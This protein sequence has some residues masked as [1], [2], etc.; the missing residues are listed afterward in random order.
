MTM[1]RRESLKTLA[2]GAGALLTF[3]TGGL[4]APQAASAQSGTP[5]GPAGPFVVPPLG[6]AFDALEP[7]IDAQTMQIHHDKHHAT[8]VSKLN[9]AV[10]NHA[11]LQKQSVEQLLTQLNKVPAV[12]RTAVRNHGGGHYNHSLLW[13]SLRKDGAR[14]PAGELEKAIN[15]AWS[16]FDAFQSKFDAAAASVFGSGW[17]WLAT[18]KGGGLSIVTTP[19][20]DS[21]L[22]QG[23]TPLLGIDVWEHAYYLKYQ[24]RRPEYISA[25][26]KV[27]DWDVIS[28]RYRRA[29]EK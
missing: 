19:N 8:Y 24:N 25:F 14:T 15:R 13:S 22:S 7:F 26:G 27:V 10:A 6:Y 11:A 20:Q 5:P 16:S 17:A 4:L 28:A 18:R 29:L 21:P 12:V 23:M 9:E 2:L 1:T 3:P